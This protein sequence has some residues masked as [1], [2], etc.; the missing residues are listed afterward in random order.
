MY[1]CYTDLIQFVTFEE[2]AEYLMLNG[3]VGEE[4]FGYRRYI[5][6]KFY[7][8]PRWLDVRE[9][10]IIRDEGCDLGIPG[11]KITGLIHVHHMNPATLEQFLSE[12][13]ALLDPENLISCSDATHRAITLGRKLLLPKP[14]VVRTPGDTCLWK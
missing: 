1:R 8:D 12:D 2:R 14:I 6:Q 7:H 3:K 10:V 11:M 5:N 4:L 13:P 9:Q